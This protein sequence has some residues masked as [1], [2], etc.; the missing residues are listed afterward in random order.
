MC[1]VPSFLFLLC[2]RLQ[3]ELGY[4]PLTLAPGITSTTITRDFFSPISYGLASSS[5]SMK[6]VRINNFRIL[7]IDITFPPILIFTHE[8]RFLQSSSL[9][10]N[11]LPP[12]P[13]VGN[14]SESMHAKA[15]RSSP[16]SSP[17]EARNPISL[18][19][20]NTTRSNRIFGLTDASTLPSSLRSTAEC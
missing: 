5:Q 4:A 7:E 13:T 1:T 6:F 16:G 14:A 19:P 11:P 17:Q 3:V 10:S 15:R 20:P 18:S 8:Y 9:H 2:V 12:F